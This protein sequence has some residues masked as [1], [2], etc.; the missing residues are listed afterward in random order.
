MKG[1]SAVIITKNEGKNLERCLLSI[2]KVVDEIV[3]VDSGSNDE[4]EHI[5]GLFKSVV[6]VNHPWEGYAKTKNYGNSIAKFDWIL[7]LDADEALSEELADSITKAKVSNDINFYRFSRL[8]NYCG[9]WIKHCHWYPDYQIRLFNKNYTTWVGNSIHEKLY[10]SPQYKILTLKG[11]CF[12]YSVQSL[13]DHLAKV[14]LYSSVWAKEAYE[15]GKRGNVFML[16]SKPFISFLNSYFIKKGFL[17]GYYGLII[18]IV[19]GISRFQRIAKL[20]NMQK[21]GKV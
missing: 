2:E 11:D 15:K 10:I 16:V 19:L 8:T 13:E 14:N 1:I 6:F 7:S 3:I 21:A 9:K 17:D 12:H 4:T 20:I 18:S 5:A